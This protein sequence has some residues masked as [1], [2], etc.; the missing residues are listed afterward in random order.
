MYYSDDHIFVISKNSIIKRNIFGH[1]W[2]LKVNE[3]EDINKTSKIK[4]AAYSLVF[5]S[6]L[7]AVCF[8]IFVSIDLKLFQFTKI[9]SFQMN[10]TEITKETLCNCTNDEVCL[11]I[12]ENLTPKCRSIVDRKDPTGCGGLCR[13]NEEYCKKIHLRVYQ[14]RELIKLN[15]STEQFNCGNRCVPMKMR[16]DG[17]INCSNGKDE[18][19]CDCDL[20]THFHCGNSTSC[21]HQSRRCDGKVDCWDNFDEAECGYRCPGERVPCRNGQCIKKEHFCDGQYQ[22]MD[23][24]DEFEGCKIRR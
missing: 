21:L 14:C 11:K 24:S 17:I 20:T 18:Q 15:C 1:K 7:I 6:I 8:G 3:T 23:K 16:C 19:N 5:T 13:I 22:C 10:F 4:I 2:I 9:K 12:V